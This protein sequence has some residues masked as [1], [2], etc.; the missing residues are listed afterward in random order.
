MTQKTIAFFEALGSKL[1]QSDHEINASDG[2]RAPYLVED[3]LE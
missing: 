3:I 1:D 2:Q